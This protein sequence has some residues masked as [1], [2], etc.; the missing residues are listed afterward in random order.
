MSSLRLD[1]ASSTHKTRFTTRGANV[2]IASSKESMLSLSRSSRSSLLYSSLSSSAENSGSVTVNVA[3]LPKP[4]ESTT[5]VPPC[6][7]T[8]PL[9]MNRPSPLPPPACN[10]FTL[11][12]MPSLQICARFSGDKPAPESVTEMTTAPSWG[13]SSN[14][15]SS[16]GGISILASSTSPCFTHSARMVT[17]PSS[18]VNFKA[19]ER[20]LRSTCARRVE[21]P[22][23]Q[24]FWKSA[25]ASRVVSLDQ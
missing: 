19:L 15:I 22:M 17:F 13:R 14:S 8:I 18:G 20:R 10:W 6:C 23:T 4:S 5:S 2:S 16:S 1:N 24:T 11:N 7:S 25:R 9:L 3:P 21:S 12:W